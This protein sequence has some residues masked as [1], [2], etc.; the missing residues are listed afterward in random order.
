MNTYKS[1]L[2]SYKCLDSWIRQKYIRSE[3]NRVQNGFVSKDDYK[4][5]K[6]EMEQALISRK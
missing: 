6:E 5:S 3:A 2:H 4:N 1:T